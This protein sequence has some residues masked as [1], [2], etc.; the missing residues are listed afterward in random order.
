MNF[1]SLM[2]FGYSWGLGW[3]MYRT[4]YQNPAKFCSG[5]GLGFEKPAAH[6]HQ[7]IWRKH[8]SLYPRIWG[9]IQVSGSECLTHPSLRLR[10]ESR[11]RVRFIF[12]FM[13]GVIWILYTTVMLSM[14]VM[15]GLQ[16]EDL[17]SKLKDNFINNLNIHLNHS[18]QV[19][20]LYTICLLVGGT[21]YNYVR[22]ESCQSIFT[23]GHFQ[24]RTRTLSG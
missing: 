4:G 20:T 9:S 7:I 3:L 11:L 13:G 17:Y 6:T 15:W 16:P 12:R 18:V 8:T 19:G 10:L 24:F 14:E 22:V 2:S 23:K 21:H 5:T 1:T